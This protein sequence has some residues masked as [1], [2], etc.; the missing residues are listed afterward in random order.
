MVLKGKF[1]NM[2]S[3]MKPTRSFIYDSMLFLEFIKKNK[4]QKQRQKEKIC[5]LFLEMRNVK[6]SEIVGI[7]SF[8]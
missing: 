7:F 8:M 5:V 1:A 3:S 6:A 2:S 4:K